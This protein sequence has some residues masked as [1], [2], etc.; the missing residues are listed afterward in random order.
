L[1]GLLESRGA[2]PTKA[3]NVDDQNGDGVKDFAVIDRTSGTV[4]IISGNHL[5]Q[6]D[7]EDDIEE[8]VKDFHLY[9]NYPNPFNPSTIIGYRLSVI[10][11]ATLKIYDTLGREI[12]VLVDKEMPAGEHKV[13]FDARKYYLS[14]GAYYYELKI[15]THHSVKKMMVIK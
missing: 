7:V 11:K 8:I 1:R 15:N 5:I 13:E 6:T 14:S 9:Q 10:S 3:I 12:A 2:F 4:M